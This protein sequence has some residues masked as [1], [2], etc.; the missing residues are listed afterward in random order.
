MVDFEKFLGGKINLDKLDP[1]F[2]S[3]KEDI[4]KSLNENAERTVKVGLAL[5]NAYVPKNEV[6][7]KLEQV[8]GKVDNVKGDTGIILE[9]ADSI[10]DNQKRFEEEQVP[11]IDKILE[12]SG[13][14]N[15]R[16]AAMQGSIQSTLDQIVE[17]KHTLNSDVN[18]LQTGIFGIQE[19][20][21]ETK[22]QVIVGNEFIAKD[23]E[24]KHSQIMEEINSTKNEVENVGGKLNKTIKDEHYKTRNNIILKGLDYAGVPKKDQGEYVGFIE[25][26]MSKGK[27]SESFYEVKHFAKIRKK[28]Q[29]LD[30]D[31]KRALTY[32]MKDGD[33]NKSTIQEFRDMEEYMV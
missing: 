17:I 4:F 15:L 19:I 11:K 25:K 13:E 9:G 3:I 1:A 28:A 21:K 8:E 6:L 7:E 2:W 27:I 23:N 33:V 10:L 26:L 12:H 20:A 24:K 16:T 22:E 5:Y 32:A 30:W 29:E 14:T 18:A 31:E